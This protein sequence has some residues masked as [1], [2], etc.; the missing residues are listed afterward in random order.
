MAAR[1][2]LSPIEGATAA[3]MASARSSSRSWVQS[4]PRANQA[5]E[6]AHNAGDGPVRQPLRAS[7]SDS[8]DLLG[9]K[10]TGSRRAGSKVPCADI[11]RRHLDPHAPCFH[12][13]GTWPGLLG[14]RSLPTALPP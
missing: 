5:R 1:I 7:S 4:G 2:G 11:T 9:P 3:A 8:G 14:H 10:A 6:G 12:F 13:A